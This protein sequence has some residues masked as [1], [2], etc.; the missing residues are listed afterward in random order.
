MSYS[1]RH[2][3]K[4]AMAGLSA[5]AIS[6]PRLWAQAHYPTF[7]ESNVRGVHL[8]MIGTALHG[9]QG[10]ERRSP[11]FSVL[12]KL[13]DPMLQPSN[14]PSQGINARVCAARSID[15]RGVRRD[16]S[17]LHREQNWVWFAPKDPWSA[18]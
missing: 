3:N 10:P 5:T 1:R 11:C 8:G 2:F 17:K 15:T 13:F 12:P 4:L 16:S 7:S 18:S 6:G 14:A 9:Q